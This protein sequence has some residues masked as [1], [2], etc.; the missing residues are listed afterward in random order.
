MIVRAAIAEAALPPTH[1]ARA[2]STEKPGPNGDA[3][4][5]LVPVDA[6]VCVHTPET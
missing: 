3:L 5:M 1:T 6:A 2:E 4:G